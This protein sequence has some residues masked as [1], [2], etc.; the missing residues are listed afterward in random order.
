M[1]ITTTTTTTTETEFLTRLKT[2]ARYA[3]KIDKSPQ[4]VYQMA[5]EGKVQLIQI[6]GV[7]FIL[8]Q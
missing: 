8:E 2:V 1:N 3:R 4:R 7:K 5:E 6:D